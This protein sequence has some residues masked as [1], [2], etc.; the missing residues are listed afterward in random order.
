MHQEAGEMAQQLREHTTIEED[1][2]EETRIRVPS[3]I[4]IEPL[5]IPLT[6]APGAAASSTLQRHWQHVHRPTHAH[7]I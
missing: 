7:L 1:Q 6:P 4:H 3:P 2:N 5:T